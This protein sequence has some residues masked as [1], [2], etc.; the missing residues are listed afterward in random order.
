MMRFLLLALAVCALPLAACA[1]SENPAA[2]NY[3]FS[4][5][6]RMRSA[7]HWNLLAEELVDDYVLHARRQSDL[8]A[9]ITVD[10]RSHTAFDKSFASFLAAHLAAAGIRTCKDA[11]CPKTMAYNAQLV[12]RNEKTV[13]TYPLSV[14]WDRMF[15]SKYARPGQ[16]EL[17][18]SLDVV[19]DGVAAFSTSQVLYVNDRDM[20]LY[21]PPKPP[22]ET[23]TFTVAQ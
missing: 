22:R 1:Y 3:A 17:V 20:H 11:A 6:H 9:A 5:Q 7:Q 13:V 14:F 21:L 23:K 18:V 15:T 19:S 12:R 8:P 10:V 16:Y 4:E 2:T